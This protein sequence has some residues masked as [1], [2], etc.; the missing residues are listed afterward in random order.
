MLTLARNLIAPHSRNKIDEEGEDVE[1]EDEGD[2]P[3]ED[4]RGVVFVFCA[5]DAEG[6]GERDFD[7]YEE[8]FG[9]E[10]GAEDA[11][12]AEVCI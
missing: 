4:G 1:G 2:G 3:F 10:G 7:D 5:G 8:E 6:D 12:L 9:P 11:V